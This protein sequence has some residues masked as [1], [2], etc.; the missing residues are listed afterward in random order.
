MTSDDVTAGGACGG[1]PRRTYPCNECPIRVDNATNPASQFPARKWAEL[2]ASVEDPVTGFGPSITDPMF[3][4]HKGAPGSDSDLACAGW[5][6]RFGGDHPRVRLAL[7]M[8]RLPESAMVAGEN[9][10][11]L[12]ES[13][14]EVVA[15]HSIG[16]TPGDGL[17]DGPGDGPGACA[18]QT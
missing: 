11:E 5:L 7:A 17:G 4:C 18:R 2:T 13:W 3:G 12:H 16:P 1:F 15:N 14:T 6:V 10:P 8:G 9:W